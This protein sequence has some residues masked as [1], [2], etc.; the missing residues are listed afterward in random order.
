MSRGVFECLQ[1]IFNPVSGG[2]CYLIHLP[3]SRF[4]CTHIAIDNAYYL[5]KEGYVFGLVDWS[6][7]PFDY[8]KRNKRIC[9]NV[10]LEVCFMPRN[11]RFYF[12]G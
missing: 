11:N 12:L 3:S 1:G 9:M 4:P 7:C 8:L 2:L 10:P 6:V 5:H